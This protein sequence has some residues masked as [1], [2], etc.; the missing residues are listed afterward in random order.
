MSS[1]GR[2]IFVCV[3]VFCLYMQL[4]PCVVTK[5]SEASEV[6]V[7]LHVAFTEFDACCSSTM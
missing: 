6:S 3:T 7:S 1:K 2:I 5:S 4:G